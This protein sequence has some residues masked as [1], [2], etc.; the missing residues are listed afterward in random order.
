MRHE[1]PT[2][3]PVVTARAMRRI[4]HGDAVAAARALLAVPRD[5]RAWVMHRMLAET[6]EA[7]QC[8]RE[9]GHAHP[10]WGDGSLMAAALRRA[11]SAEP[12]LEDPSYCRVLAYV[13]L[14]LAHQAEGGLPLDRSGGA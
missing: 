2:H 4:M 12:P 5:R 9:T 6:R 7:E 13:Y 3:A 8:R 14:S 1:A 10:V 11:V